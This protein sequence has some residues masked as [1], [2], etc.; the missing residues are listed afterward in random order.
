MLTDEVKEEFQRFL[1]HETNFLQI[2]DNLTEEKLRE[3][4]LRAL[5]EICQ[6]RHLRLDMSE[7]GTLVR[8]IVSAVVSLGPLRPLMEDKGITEIMVN[9]ANKVYIQRDGKIT[10]TD[11]KFEDNRHLLHTIQ[12]ILAGSGTNKRVDESSP[13]VDFTLPD[14]SRVNVIIPPCSML[15][16]IM[17]IRKFRDDIAGVD[18]LLKLK[19]IDENIATLLIGAMKAKLNVVFCGSTGAGKTTALNVFSQYIPEHERVITIEDTQELKLKQQHVVPLISKPPN[20]EGRGEIL[21]RELFINSL[22][23]RPDRIIIGEVRGSEMLDLIMSISSGHSGSLAI[24]HAESPEDCFNRMVTMMLLAGIGLSVEELQ[25]QIAKAV[26]VVVHIELFMDGLRR[27]SYVTDLVHDPETHR[28]SLRHIFE[29][30]ETG[31]D[32]KGVIQGYWAMN[33]TTPTFMHKFIKRRV[34]LPP[35]FFEDKPAKSEHGFSVG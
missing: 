14:G 32:E 26:D 4:V 18:D 2:K 16:P 31:V 1:L 9:G 28:V 24:V 27:F 35:G 33:K 21:M 19:M 8:L 34:S 29:F 17:T 5:E 23:M 25:K 11:F 15:G 3:F 30:K 6:T 12:K 20:I 13:Y 22:R 10:L 7:R